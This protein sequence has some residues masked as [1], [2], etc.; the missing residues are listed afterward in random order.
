MKGNKMELILGSLA[1]A[2]SAVLLGITWGMVEEETK[3]SK[4]VFD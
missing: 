3:K 2:V 1:L 4:T